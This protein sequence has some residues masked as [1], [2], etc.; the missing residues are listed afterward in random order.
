[1]LKEAGAYGGS[2]GRCLGRQ[3]G[4]VLTGIGQVLEGQVLKEAAWAGACKAGA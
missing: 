1:M 3:L 2:L 4:Q